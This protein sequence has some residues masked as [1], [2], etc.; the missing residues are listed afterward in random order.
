MQVIDF[1]Q[2]RIDREREKLER[3]ANPSLASDLVRAAIAYAMILGAT[4]V[5]VYVVLATPRG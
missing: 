4:W 2:R 3:M 5:I 1:E